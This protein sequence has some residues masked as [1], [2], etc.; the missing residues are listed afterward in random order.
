MINKICSKPMFGLMMIVA[1]FVSSCK[2]G[3]A[4]I[5]ENAKEKVS[6]VS[7]AVTVDVEDGVGVTV[8]VGVGG[9]TNS[10]APMSQPFP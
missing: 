2:P 10:N 3:D 5:A 1:L 4:K 6:S 9:N 7:P 8:S